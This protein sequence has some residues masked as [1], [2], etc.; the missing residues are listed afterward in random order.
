[1][2]RY[3]EPLVFGLATLGV[4]VVGTLL[5]GWSQAIFDVYPGG[6]KWAAIGALGF[7]AGWRRSGI[8]L[9]AIVLVDSGYHLVHWALVGDP[10]EAT[11]FLVPTILFY[12]VVAGGAFV[13]GRWLGPSSVRA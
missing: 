13:V 12:V 4:Q 9:L 7:A 11:T 6:L 2:R 5:L 8:A 1:M 3:A 10:G